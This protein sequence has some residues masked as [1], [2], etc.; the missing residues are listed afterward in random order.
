MGSKHSSSFDVINIL[1]I[2]L[3]GVGKTH[4]LDLFNGAS[5]LMKKPT[6]GFYEATYNNEFHFVEYGGKSSWDHLFHNYDVIYMLIDNEYTQEQLL[7]ARSA[8]L[9]MCL[10]LPDIPLVVIFK[11]KGKLKHQEMLQLEEIA[12]ERKV[13]ISHL[14]FDKDECQEGISRLFEWTKQNR[15]TP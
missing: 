13:G 9:M 8:M 4:F 11:G 6:N 1:V 5:N 10:K 7:E 3:S 12:L 15:G 14:D 2:G